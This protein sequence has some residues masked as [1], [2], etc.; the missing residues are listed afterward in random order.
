MSD[1][2]SVNSE[3]SA[4]GTGLRFPISLQSPTWKFRQRTVGIDNVRTVRGTTTLVLFVVVAIRAGLPNDYF[5]LE[6]LLVNC[7]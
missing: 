1:E 2:Y 4:A 6:S 3:Y 7:Y 5:P